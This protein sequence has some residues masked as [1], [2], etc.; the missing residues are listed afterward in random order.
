MPRIV[1]VSC[2]VILFL[3]RDWERIC[4]QNHFWVFN[5]HPE[6]KQYANNEISAHLGAREN[7]FWLKCISTRMLFFRNRGDCF[8]SQR[9]MWR[10]YLEAFYGWGSIALLVWVG[11]KVGQG[12]IG[13]HRLISSRIMRIIRKMTQYWC[14]HGAKV[15]YEMKVG[16][17]DRFL[18]RVQSV[19][20]I[21]PMPYRFVDRFDSVSL[22]TMLALLGLDMVV[23]Q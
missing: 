14:G 2:S 18:C 20:Q 17:C 10:I 16:L 23:K 8:F 22:A 4:I 5:P 6:F 9:W 12:L 19:Q 7:T 21:K 3:Q 15:V 11:I 13:F 1:I